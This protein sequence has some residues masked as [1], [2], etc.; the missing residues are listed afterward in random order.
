[1][2]LRLN[3]VLIEDL[4]DDELDLF[5]GN[6]AVLARE[7]VALSEPITIVDHWVRSWARAAR[8]SQRR[9]MDFDPLFEVVS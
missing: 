9:G 4:A 6:L 1:M 8:E 7:S 3:G 2:A 5:T